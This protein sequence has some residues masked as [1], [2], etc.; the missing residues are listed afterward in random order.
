MSRPIR[1]GAAPDLEEDTAE[2]LDADGRL[3]AQ[4]TLACSRAPAGTAALRL[5]AEA[6][7]RIW[8]AL[9]EAHRD[10]NRTGR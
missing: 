5:P 9:E 4:F 7:E 6:C 3:I 2:A 8:A 1:I 10:L